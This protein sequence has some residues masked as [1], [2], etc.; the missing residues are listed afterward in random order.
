MLD[1][2]HII[3]ASGKVKINELNTNGL[4]I[5]GKLAYCTMAIKRII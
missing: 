4:T 1:K 5:N 2:K 3:H